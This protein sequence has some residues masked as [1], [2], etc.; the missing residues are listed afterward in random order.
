MNILAKLSLGSFG[1]LLMTG[2]AMASMPDIEHAIRDQPGAYVNL[3]IAKTVASTDISN[4]CG[5]VP[6]KLVYLDHQGREHV[7]NYQV[8]GSGCANQH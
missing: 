8:E 4:K 5:V 7:L 1:L 6:A 3:D 2:T